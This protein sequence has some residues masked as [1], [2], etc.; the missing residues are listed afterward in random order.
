MEVDARNTGD[1]WEG[2]GRP[3]GA[4]GWREGIAAAERWMEKRQ[5]KKSVMRRAV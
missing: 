2:G 4:G 5:V 1:D 3:F